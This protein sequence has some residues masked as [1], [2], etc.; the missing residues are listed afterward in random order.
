M[1]SSSPRTAMF[2][3]SMQ[4]KR[5]STSKWGVVSHAGLQFHDYGLWT[6]APLMVA[7]ENPTEST[8]VHKNVQERP[9]ILEQASISLR[10]DPAQGV[11]K[12]MAPGWSCEP[13]LGDLRPGE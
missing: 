5:R 6:G 4:S 8:L 2:S 13:F 10:E 3:A 9:K 11:P 1:L 7:S 12:R